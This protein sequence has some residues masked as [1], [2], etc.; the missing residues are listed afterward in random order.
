VGVFGFRLRGNSSRFINHSCDPNCELQKW[1]VRGFTHIG[2]VAIQDIPSGTS[3]SY[4]YQ[5]ATGDRNKFKVRRPSPQSA[6]GSLAHGTGRAC[7]VI[8]NPFQC[9]CG[10]AACRGSL[11][12]KERRSEDDELEE[13]RKGKV[14]G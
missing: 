2:I 13:L 1:N 7:A 6:R 5:F 9:Y 12:P 14:T 10:T 3:L 8:P 4:D 11:A